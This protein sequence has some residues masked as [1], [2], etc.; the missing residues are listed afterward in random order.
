MA[1]EK[2]PLKPRQELTDNDAE[3]LF[4]EAFCL[5]GAFVPQTPQ[6]VE[7][8]EE[9]FFDE[10]IDLPTSLRNPLAILEGSG[11]PQSKPR[12]SPYIDSSV[13][14]NLACAAR[15]GGEISSE[16]EASM[17]KDEE[18]A[19]AERGRDNGKN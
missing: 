16:I 13:V 12:S 4:Y 2:Q 7:L 5:E 3:R 17:V 6:E 15:N 10:S 19:E 14:D 8:A 1:T 9:D 18:E 11:K